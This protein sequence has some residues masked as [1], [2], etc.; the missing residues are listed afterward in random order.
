MARWGKRWGVCTH[1]NLRREEE[2]P[3]RAKYHAPAPVLPSF[4]MLLPIFG[5][6]AGGTS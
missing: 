3:S 5:G 6:G 1:S 2:D 4:A